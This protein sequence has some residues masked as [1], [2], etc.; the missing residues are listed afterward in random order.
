MTIPGLY[1]H[2]KREKDERPGKHAVHCRYDERV[3]ETTALCIHRFI[4]YYL[5]NYLINKQCRFLQNRLNTEDLSNNSKSNN[6]N[7][8]KC[9]VLHA[10]V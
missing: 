3:K 9:P 1:G 7:E 6:N 2:D 8:K 4:R 10:L 5:F